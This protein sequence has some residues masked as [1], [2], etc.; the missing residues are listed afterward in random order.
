MRRTSF[1]IAA[2]AALSFALAP[3]LADARSGGGN[4][5]G[6]RGS[7]TNAAPAPTN[8]APAA[9]PMQRTTT[10]QATP[11]PNAATA[12]ATA[13]MSQR[14]PFM[15]GLMGGL[16]GAGIIGL[17]FGGSLFGGIGGI[18]S[19]LWFLVQIA[20]L[21]L[22]G[23]FVWRLVSR[24]IASRN[25]QPAYAGAPNLMARGAVP[26][27]RQT[28]SGGGGA[29]AQPALAIAPADYAAFEQLLQAVQAAWSRQDLNALRATS[30]PEMSGYF[31]EQL[32]E[33][34]NRGVRNMVTDVKL[35]QGDLSEGWSEGNREYATVAMRFS[36]VDVT[37]DAGDRVVD[38][39]PERRTEATEFWT[40]MRA[41]GSR[42]MLSAIQQTR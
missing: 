26:D 32:A 17:L 22:V 24:Y 20:L 27:A 38:G 33:Q 2:L 41:P 40:F 1:A 5:M 19:F 36:M 11:G 42:W 35:E 39:D 30:T 14:S 10:P 8:T 28:A 6:S 37:R 16:L 34:A 12:G 13:G 4:S 18:G 15:S 21:V 7:R 29:P 23:R 25:G 3:G 9:A 31:T